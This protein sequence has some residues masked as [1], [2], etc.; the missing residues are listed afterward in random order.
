LGR[1]ST[2][3]TGAYGQCHCQSNPIFF[4]NFLLLH[5][6]I[7]FDLNCHFWRFSINQ[8]AAPSPDSTTFAGRAQ[9][10]VL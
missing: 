4:H 3:H 6:I 7:Q 8:E 9:E 1:E 10:A 5:S 2:R